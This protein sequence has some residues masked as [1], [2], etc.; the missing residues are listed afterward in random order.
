MKAH[1]S[2]PSMTQCRLPLLITRRSRVCRVFPHD[3]PVTA[4]E[5]VPSQVVSLCT[6]RAQE[7]LIEP[8]H[9]EERLVDARV[10]TDT[11]TE[12]LVSSVFCFHLLSHVFSNVQLGETR[13]VTIQS[14]DLAIE[15]MLS[16]SCQSI[17]LTNLHAMQY[18]HKKA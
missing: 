13:Q 3:L 8:R 9:I 16:S 4:I 6:G 14:T 7:H 18:Q 1:Y 12:S 17:R 5:S 2:M 10:Q 11:S 15:L